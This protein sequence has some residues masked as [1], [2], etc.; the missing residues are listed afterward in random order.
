MY[1]SVDKLTAP[2]LIEKKKRKE[3]RRGRSL[4]YHMPQT[5]IANF[6]LRCYWLPACLFLIPV[7][8]YQFVLNFMFCEEEIRFPLI[9]VFLF[10]LLFRGERTCIVMSLICLLKVFHLT[11]LLF[12]SKISSFFPLVLQLSSC[13]LNRQSQDLSSSWSS[14]LKCSEEISKMK[15]IERFQLISGSCLGLEE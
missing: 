5:R 10:L 12:L 1:R 13:G 2:R 6:F 4:L 11:Y 7:I 3:V 15:R 9:E 8:M 14:S